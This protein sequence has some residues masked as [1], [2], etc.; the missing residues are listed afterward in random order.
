MNV[1]FAEGYTSPSQRIRVIS[2]NWLAKNGYCPTCGQNL[3]AAKVNA[4][5]FDFECVSCAH[6]FELKSQRAIKTVSKINDGA[7]SSMMERIIDTKSPHFFF[8]GYN[9]KFSVT[10]LLA[11]PNYF[12]QSSVIEKRKPLAITAKRAGW[13]SCNI[14]LDQIPEIG[15]IKLVQNGEIIPQEAVIKTWKKTAFLAQENK[16]EARGWTLD[17]MKCIERIQSKEFSLESLYKFE[18]ELAHNHPLNNF[19]KDKIRQQ[20]QVLRDKG[21]LDFVRPRYYKLID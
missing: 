13:V 12:F 19:V 17:V 8:L 7:Y 14:L 21:Y 4:R 11:V 18:P 3:K 20:L 1:G 6:E 5:V 15:K 2:E 10:N 16:I 9:A